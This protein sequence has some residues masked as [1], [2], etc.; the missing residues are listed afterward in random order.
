MAIRRIR[1]LN[2]ETY[3][4]PSS[5]LGSAANARLFVEWL[6]D[7]D[8][9]RSLRRTKIQGLLDGNAPWSRGTLVAKG[10]GHRTNLNLREGEGAVDAAKT[11]YYD[12]VFEVPRFANITMD[13][14]QMD[15]EMNYEWS[16]IISDEF[17]ETLDRWDG[18]DMLIQLH[19]YQMVVFGVGPI[20]W[21]H[22]LDWRAESGKAGRLLV[23]QRTKANTE[24]LDVLV[25]LHTFGPEELFSLVKNLD[26]ERK[27]DAAGWNPE[28]CKKEIVR[29]AKEGD[30]VRSSSHYWE[31]IQQ[32][33]RNGDL[34]HAL[35]QSNDVRVATVYIKEFDGKVSHYI[36][37]RNPD[38]AENL[39]TDAQR[40][41]VQTDADPYHTINDIE[42]GYLYKAKAKFE[43]FSQV[44]C[45]FFYDVGPDGTW[46]SIK[47]YGP[48]L[49]DFCDVSNRMTSHMI[50][51]AVIGSGVSLEAQDTNALQETQ[52]SLFGG[53]AVFAP[54]LKVVQTRIAESLNGAIAVKRELQNTLQANTGSYRQR[55]SGEQEEP[56]LGQAQM[57][58]QQQA[59]LSKGAVNRYYKTLDRFYRETLRRLLNPK[60][61][62]SDPGGEEAFYFR[63]CCM[64]RGIPEEF[65]TFEHVRRVKSMRSL[66][67]GSPQIRDIA[68]Q[69]LLQLVPMMSERA[70]NTALRLRVATIPGAGQHMV[71]LFFPK[72]EMPTSHDA[73]ATNEN[74]FLRQADGQTQVTPEQNHATHFQRHYADVMQHAQQV[75]Q[76]QGK[77]H[78]LLIHLTKAGPHMHQ[79]L[80][81]IKN[82]PMRK[83]QVKQ[84]SDGLTVLS[85]MQDRLHKQMNQQNAQAP[86]QPGPQL[87]PEHIAAMQKV[88]GEL[89]IKRQ[90]MH[91][92]LALKAE[93][94]KFQTRISDLKTA[95]DIRRKRNGS[96][97]LLQ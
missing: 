82:D 53:V 65:L 56:T 7:D 76:G 49:Y 20:Y 67:Y 17:H 50:D 6:K 87:D 11:P 34:Y 69:Q 54:G 27:S 58:Q 8:E 43:N 63:E 48:K 88:Q 92:E 30:T 22:A 35:S 10:Q 44:V 51:G 28:L 93:K 84:M 13:F 18:F 83:Q 2:P 14:E 38:P 45:P 64:E 94:Q 95:A 89:E 61:K 41:E 60:L 96:Q 42:V 72:Q 33:Y 37:G 1:T 97:S 19:Q 81:Q 15:F 5:R 46:H 24:K 74:N 29:A 3:E 9:T 47:G 36:V 39:V 12:L 70:R 66:G 85:K 80:E 68:S 91:G 26:E 86:N 78:D 73:D 52:V 4:P 79:H 75:Q 31:R 59:M 71:D 32:E 23:P 21:P 55:V 40:R 90:K 57:N 62:R 16:E 77:A 25:I